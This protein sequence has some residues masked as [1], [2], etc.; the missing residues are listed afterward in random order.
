MSNW[1]TARLHRSRYIAANS[2]FTVKLSQCPTSYC[3]NT[4]QYNFLVL[5]CPSA[6]LPHCHIVPLPTYHWPLSSTFMAPLPYNTFGPLLLSPLGPVV[7]HM[8][9]VF[10]A[11]S[12]EFH[13]SLRRPLPHEINAKRNLIQIAPI[14]PY[15]SFQHFFT[16][17]ESCR[18][19]CLSNSSQWSQYT[20]MFVESSKKKYN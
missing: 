1:P 18:H 2:H 13:A 17:L 6:S 3:A 7:M 19:E 9:T 11:A 5:H 12:K 15:I 14:S 8:E 4:L 20:Y 10:L 16:E